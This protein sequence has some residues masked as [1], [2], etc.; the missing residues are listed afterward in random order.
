MPVCLW[1]SSYAVFLRRMIF[2]LVIF[3]CSF[4]FCAFFMGYYWNTI[5]L[6]TVCITP[7]V[8]LGT[9]KLFTEGKFRL[10]IVSLALSLLTNYYIGLFACI[11][12]TVVIH[13]IQHCKMGRHQKVCNKYSSHRHL[14]IDCNRT[15]C[16]FS[17]CRHSSVC[18]TQTHR[19]QLSRQP[20]QSI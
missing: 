1:Q 2:S 10:Y 18:K 6:D 20:L 11:F 4:G 13:C 19:G 12:C 9:V 8:A 14:L 15:Y 17:C 3:G 16:V 5:W 7:L